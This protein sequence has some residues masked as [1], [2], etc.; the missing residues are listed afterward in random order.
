MKHLSVLTQ[1]NPVAVARLYT[2]Y[3]G[4]IAI[5]LSVMAAPP[6]GSIPTGGYR[7]DTVCTRYQIHWGNSLSFSLSTSVLVRVGVSLPS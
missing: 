2:L 5:A 7:A 1:Y 3:T 4:D 6:R